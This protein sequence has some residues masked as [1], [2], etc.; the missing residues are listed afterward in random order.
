MDLL[1]AILKEFSKE[2]CRR[3]VKYV[4][5]D[6]KKFAELMKHFL[7][8]EPLVAQ[9]SGWPLSYCVEEHPDFITPYYKQIV[10][11]LEK[12]DSHEAVVRNIVR[13]LQYAD[14]PKRRS[15]ERRVGKE[16]RSRWSPYH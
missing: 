10:D 12:P 8:G 3:I 15:E 14:I 7:N 5:K 1:Q 13:L 2:Q 9:R 6:E 16:C 11:R 4:G